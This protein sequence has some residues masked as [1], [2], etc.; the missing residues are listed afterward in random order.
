MM[1]NKYIKAFLVL[2][3]MFFALSCR[4]RATEK[5][6][7]EEFGAPYLLVAT[8]SDKG[9]I[10][11]IDIK[12]REVSDS[13]KLMK[14]K[15]IG[16]SAPVFSF[17]ALSHTASVGCQIRDFQIHEKS[18]Y[19]LCDNADTL[20]KY[21]ASSLANSDSPKILAQADVGP[22]SPRIDISHDGSK[23]AVTNTSDNTV[24]V[25]DSNLNLLDII[26]DFK[27]N[28]PISSIWLGNNM[29]VSDGQILCEIED[30][31][32]GDKKRIASKGSIWQLAL[33]SQTQRLFALVVTKD[34]ADS[35]MMVSTDFAS[36]T[37][38][39]IPAYENLMQYL[40]KHSISS[41]ST[42]NYD[43]GEMIEVAPTGTLV[44][45]AKDSSVDV[46]TL[47]ESSGSMSPTDIIRN[48][49]SADSDDSEPVFSGSV[50]SC[51]V[52]SARAMTFYQDRIL[53]AGTGT[54]VNACL[55]RDEDKGNQTTSYSYSGDRNA[56]SVPNEI[57]GLA[58][59]NK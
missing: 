47:P 18:A 7:T 45:I 32:V 46:L 20:V 9:N 35:T 12:E 24:H 58:I 14:T 52:S 54:Q 26:S 11:V 4:N 38:F 59:V 43:G 8:G 25:Y 31:K 40:K 19:V 55:M 41:N 6:Q 13:E 16:S 49:D 36:S 5:T 39:E 21:S 23:I 3:L 28:S 56:I 34:S 48:A 57:K 22:G 17:K 30:Y 2:S 37:I 42:A 50:L 15:N 29:Y 44:A 51:S 10:S 27:E 33:S 1:T 53:F